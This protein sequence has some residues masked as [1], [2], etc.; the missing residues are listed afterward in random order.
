M[1]PA[2]KQPAATEELQPSPDDAVDLNAAWE[3][4]YEDTLRIINLTMSHQ[5][6]A[7]QSADEI[8]A[9]LVDV[10]STAQREMEEANANAL[11]D[12]EDAT[13]S[14]AMYIAHLAA[15]SEFDEQQAE[16][17]QQSETTQAQVHQVEAAQSEVVD[18]LASETSAM[19]KSGDQV[20]IGG[21]PMTVIEGY[22]MQNTAQTPMLIVQD[23]L[24]NQKH[25]KVSAIE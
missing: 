12:P 25:V 17:A 14:N 7:G 5:R 9:S 20:A 22:T 8:R 13:R 18:A 19:F 23:K 21:E 16:V 3:D 1:L 4:S 15:I 24:G 6:E 10:L 11:N 2:Y